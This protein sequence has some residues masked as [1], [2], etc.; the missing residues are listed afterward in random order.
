MSEDAE[1]QALLGRMLAM[2]AEISLRLTEIE[3]EQEMADAASRRH[4]IFSNKLLTLAKRHGRDI[5]RVDRERFDGDTSNAADLAA[6]R[7]DLG[8]VEPSP[9]L[10]PEPP[11]RTKLHLVRR[12]SP[13]DPTHSAESVARSRLETGPGRYGVRSG[14]GGLAAA[15]ASC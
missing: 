10:Q 9:P 8:Y 13:A 4:R 12:A 14:S 7:S 15:S 3:V 6:L 2:I 1:T 11:P 5:E